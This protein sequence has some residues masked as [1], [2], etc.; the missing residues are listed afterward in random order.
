M[1]RIEAEAWKAML[2]HARR[3]YPD[4]C[5][6]AMLGRREDGL[7]LVLRAVPLDNVFPG[8][9]S[10]RYEVSPADLLRTERLARQEGLEL[11]GIYHSHPDCP[12]YFSQTDLENSCPWYSFVVLSIC[13]GRFA[14]AGS[15]LPDEQQSCATQEEIVYPQLAI[16]DEEPICPRS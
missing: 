10:A 4:E 16:E 2:E 13:K 9:R 1:I 5:C 11:L 3:C 12:A 6:G 7:K 14:G 15:W 8:P